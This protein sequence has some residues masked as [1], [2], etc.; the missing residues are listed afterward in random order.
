MNVVVTGGGTVAPIDEVR[1]ITNLSTGRFSAAITEAWLRRGDTVT[2]VHAG[3]ALLPFA[4]NARLDLDV[5]EDRL[6]A[7][8]ARLEALRREYRSARG[9]LRL[10]PLR[11]GTVA[12]YAATLETEL[13]GGHV[14]VVMLAMAVSDYEPVPVPGK[15]GSDDATLVVHCRRTPKVIRSVRAWAPDVFLVGFKL[16]VGTSPEALIRR[17]EDD[18]RANGADLT[19]ANDLGP[20]REGRH[21]VHLVRPGQPAETFGPSTTL[22]DEVVARVAAMAAASRPGRK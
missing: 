15:I 3:G 14:D 1:A 5:S 12:D 20:L 17:A 9:R 16:M 19:L 4:R 11:K 8:L 7:E 18:G 2:H 13:R 22:A 10:V 21:T 6:A